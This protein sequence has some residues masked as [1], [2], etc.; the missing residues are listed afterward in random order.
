VVGCAVGR[1]YAE[2]CGGKMR[3]DLGS[4]IRSEILAQRMHQRVARRL[5]S[6]LLHADTYARQ[7][8]MKD[9]L[10]DE[11]SWRNS[12]HIGGHGGPAYPG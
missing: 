9:T 7:A 12:Q 4:R 2:F 1:V 11:E 3:M 8:P 6:I 10:E 5:A